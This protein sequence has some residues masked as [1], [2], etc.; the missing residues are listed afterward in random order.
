MSAP[1]ATTAAT[2]SPS[3]AKSEDKMLGAIRKVRAAIVGNSTWIR[4][5]PHEF[6]I[7]ALVSARNFVWN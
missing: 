2:S 1:A 5:A 7:R 3:R 4:T 6:A